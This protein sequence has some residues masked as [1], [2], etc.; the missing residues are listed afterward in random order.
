ME[1]DGSYVDATH[2]VA[3]C[4]K[5]ALLAVIGPSARL[6]AHTNGTRLRAVGFRDRSRSGELVREKSNQDTSACGR[7]LLRLLASHLPRCVVERFSNDRRRVGKHLGNRTRRLVADVLDLPRALGEVSVF[8]LG[9][10]LVFLTAVFAAGHPSLE[11]GEFLVPV[12]DDRFGLASRHDDRRATIG[13]G[14]QAVDAEVH[15][16]RD[17]AG[18]NGSAC[19]AD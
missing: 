14:K 9:E 1:A 13:R 3:W 15:A 2:D 12:L 6:P 4:D 5:A 10:A 8:P 7:D 18:C 19:L 17:A 11:R 16:D